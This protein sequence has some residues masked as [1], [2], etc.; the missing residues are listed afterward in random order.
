[1]SF[2][3]LAHHDRT[4][5][6]DGQL[7][8][9]DGLTPVQLSSGDKVRFKAGRAGE[10]PILDLVSD[11]ATPNGSRV[12]ITSLGDS[13]NAAAYRVKVSEFDLPDSVSPGAYDADLSIID[14]S[15]TNPSNPTQPVEFGVFHVLGSPAGRRGFGTH[16]A[17]AAVGMPALGVSASGTFAP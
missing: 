3:I 8:R 7:F 2:E 16:G 9:A 13:S 1:M 15:G 6:Y 17:S 14:V 4:S 11:L 5:E 12:T 10:A